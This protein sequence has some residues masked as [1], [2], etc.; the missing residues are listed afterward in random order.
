MRKLLVASVLALAAW[1][2]LTASAVTF[3]L[4]SGASN[5]L[6]VGVVC[7]VS[8]PCS[9]TTNNAFD[10][11]SNAS[12]SGTITFASALAAG[13]N[14]ASLSVFV[15]S[16]TFTGVGANGVDTIVFTSVTYS[17]TGQTA[18]VS[19]V[20]GNWS[21]AGAGS[22]TG[23]VSGTYTQSGPF[24]PV[25]GPTA[26]SVPANFNSLACLISKTTNTGQCGF[27]F[28]GSGTGTFSLPIG[29]SDGSSPGYFVNTFNTTVPEPGT[30]GLL[31][32]GVGLLALVRRHA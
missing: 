4:V 6:D 3:P 31:G 10:L 14:S 24:G 1:L 5:G 21:I 7:M 26:F 28:G 22:V 15:P 20:G 19:S 18:F 32:L 25:A 13:L 23:T 8:G 27:T 11:A 16:A 29:P 30:L 12:A 2:P 9:P 17:M